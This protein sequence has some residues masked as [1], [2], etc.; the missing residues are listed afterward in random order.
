MWTLL[1]LYYSVA[2]HSV[3][4]DK[5]KYATEETCYAARAEVLSPKYDNVAE[6]R[7]DE[8]PEYNYRQSIANAGQV[9][10]QGLMQGVAR[11]GEPCGSYSNPCNVKIK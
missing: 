10:S 11:V 5:R 4:I 8:V 6:A 2:T 1:V 3:E 9:F 7:C